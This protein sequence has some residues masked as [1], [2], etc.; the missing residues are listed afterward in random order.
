MSVMLELDPEFVLTE[1]IPLGAEDLRYGLER[2]F[3]KP[4]G[5]VDLSVE[6]VRRGMT[7]PVL[8]DLA[9]LLRDEVDEV[10]EVLKALDDPER[11]HDPRESA[12]KWLYLQ[13]SAAFR[14]RGAL[15]D[16]LGV[17]EQIYADF[18]YP[19][20]LAPLV[21]YMPLSPGDEAGETAL[22][23]RWAE[24]LKREHEALTRRP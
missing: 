16:P 4:P 14:D 22:M 23:Q 1:G 12:R 6:E 8:N 21:R 19:P 7:D 13:L 11:I 3:I 2:G 10:Q 9:A 17:V 5:V 15:S 24:F 18:D 20:A